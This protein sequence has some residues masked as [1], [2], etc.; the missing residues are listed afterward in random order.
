MISQDILLIGQLDSLSEPRGLSILH[1]VLPELRDSEL[2]TIFSSYN[3]LS[4]LPT[5]QLLFQS[6]VPALGL[7]AYLY[8]DLEKAMA[9][10]SSTFAWKIP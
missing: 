4:F 6:P 2:T 8:H 5:K 10:H 3:F 9:P 1:A 7:F